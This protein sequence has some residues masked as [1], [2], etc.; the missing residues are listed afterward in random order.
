MFD[1]TTGLA[2]LSVTVQHLDGRAELALVGE[3]DISTIALLRRRLERLIMDGHREMRLNASG[4]R[5]IDASGVGAL[6]QIQHQVQEL[7]GH[8]AL[9]SVQRLPLRLIDLCGVLD[10]LVD[11]RRSSDLPETGKTR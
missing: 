3:L 5:F 7:G 8:L 4:L 11:T 6:L 2:E 1:P 10:A 9:H